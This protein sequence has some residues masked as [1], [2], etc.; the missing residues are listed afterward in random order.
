MKKILV[1][2]LLTN[3]LCYNTYEQSKQEFLK[4]DIAVYDECFGLKDFC[5]NGYLKCR[6][7]CSLMFE[8][9]CTQ[10]VMPFK[11]HNDRKIKCKG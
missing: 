2:F 7:D 3:L 1:V 11:L 9:I 6:V 8:N 5:Y 10:S 4:R